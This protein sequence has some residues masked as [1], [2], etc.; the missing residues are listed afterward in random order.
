MGRQRMYARVCA[1][2]EGTSCAREPAT[3]EP[4]Q[5]PPKTEQ[6][7]KRG[8]WRAASHRAD[9]HDDVSWLGKVVELDLAPLAQ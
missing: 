2:F 9:S 7:P 5:A 3:C 1:R 6:R 4:A 8:G